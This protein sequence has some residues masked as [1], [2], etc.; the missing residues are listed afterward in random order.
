MVYELSPGSNSTWTEKIL[1]NFIT[2][3]NDGTFPDSK[4]TLDTAGNVYGTTFS[5]GGP[6]N[7]GIV[8]ELTPDTAGHWTE[9]VLHNFNQMTGDGVGPS[10]SLVFDASGNLYGATINGG[11][12][13]RG[14]VFELSPSAD[15]TW[16]ETILNNFLENGA[17]YWPNSGPILFNGSLFGINAVGGGNG[18]GTVFQLAP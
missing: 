14:T 13:G 16:T 11:N 18:Q 10:N 12:H 9:K 3:N 15:G 8:Y 17:G 4:L 2:N 1:H 6:S 5:G 7:A